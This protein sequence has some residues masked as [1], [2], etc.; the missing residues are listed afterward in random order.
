MG[1][2]ALTWSFNLR[3]QDMAA[4]AAL[5][6][7]ADHANEEGQC[8]PSMPR[9]ALFAGCSVKTARR[10]VQRLTDLG[11]IRR[12]SRP[13]RS[14]LYTIDLCWS[15]SQAMRP[16]RFDHSRPDQRAL[17]NWTDTPAISTRD[18][19][20]LGSRTTTNRQMNPQKTLSWPPRDPASEQRVMLPAD[21]RPTADDRQHATDKGLNADT[22]EVSFIDYFSEGGGRNQK[23][24]LAGWSRRFRAWCNTEADR[25]ASSHSRGFQSARGNDPFYQRLI[26]ISARG[27]DEEPDS[28]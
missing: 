13:G 17:P 25:R 4:K 1:L 14:D 21:W 16:E 12:E 9:I 10:A 2:R 3:L 6:A 15:P 8:W 20:R 18:T 19:S 27:R 24:T 26:D 5:L 28:A 22:V 11:I 7:L 23:R